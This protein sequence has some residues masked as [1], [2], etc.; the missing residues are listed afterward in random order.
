V[1]LR[2]AIT[3]AASVVVPSEHARRIIAIMCGWAAVLAGA[4]LVFGGGDPA[5]GGIVAV[6]AGTFLALLGPEPRKED[7]PCN[8]PGCPVLYRHRHPR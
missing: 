6:S 1:R 3:T 2:N 5:L 8:I 7:P 4:F